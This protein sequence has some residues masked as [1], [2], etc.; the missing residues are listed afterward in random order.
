MNEVEKRCRNEF[1]TLPIR[2]TM[3]RLRDQFEAKYEEGTSQ[4]DGNIETVLQASEG[5]C[6]AVIL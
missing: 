1:G 4:F 3:A 2:E 6:E 5:A